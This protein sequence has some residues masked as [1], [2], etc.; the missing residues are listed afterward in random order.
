MESGAGCA[1]VLLRL[2]WLR[3][4]Q[5]GITP[6]H[7]ACK[8]GEEKVVKHLLAHAADAAALDGDGNTP[9]HL[10]AAEGFPDG[11][12]AASKQASCAK[13]LCAALRKT[14]AANDVANKDGKSPLDVAKDAHTRSR[15]SKLMAGHWYVGSA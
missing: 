13:Q 9:L 15:L 6:L 7:E 5:K 3:G 10:A 1:R 11:M 14:G 2:T 4:A 12:F 8:E